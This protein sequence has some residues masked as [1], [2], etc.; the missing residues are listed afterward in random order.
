[1]LKDRIVLVEQEIAKLVDSCAKMYTEVAIKDN[2]SPAMQSLYEMKLGMLHTFIAERN[3]IL[4]LLAR[5]E[6]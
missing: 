6:E 1:M 2:A 4:E 3:A 5:G